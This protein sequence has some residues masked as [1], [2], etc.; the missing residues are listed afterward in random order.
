MKALKTSYVF[1]SDVTSTG[2]FKK[3]NFL[4]LK[5]VEKTKFETEE[6]K[7]SYC[8]ERHFQ[9][10][11]IVKI[12]FLFSYY[13]EKNLFLIINSLSLKWTFF[14]AEIVDFTGCSYDWEWTNT[15]HTFS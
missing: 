7:C 6:T 9:M 4:C 10:V 2:L 8:F 3:I 15:L 11:P 12:M 5:T 13:I 14:R 1:S